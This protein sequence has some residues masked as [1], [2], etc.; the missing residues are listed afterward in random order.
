MFK[1]WFHW[2]YSG[3]VIPTLWVT[4][5]AMATFGI[6]FDTPDEIGIFSLLA[7]L[8]FGGT[9]LYACGV[10]ITSDWLRNVA[11]EIQSA[12]T[13]GRYTALAR[14]C[15]YIA[16]P[17]LTMTSVLI[18]CVLFTHRAEQQHRLSTFS[19]VLAP[20]DDQTIY[21]KPIE[22]AQGIVVFG[23]SAIQF[24]SM[25]AT[26]LRVGKE[27][28]I[29]M[30]RREGGGISISAKIYSEDGRIVTKVLKNAFDI[31]RN[32]IFKEERPD[33]STLIVIDQHDQRVLYIRYRNKYEIQFDARLWS[34]EL[35]LF[36]T[37][38][39]VQN[40]CINYMAKSSK[41]VFGFGTNDAI[42]RLD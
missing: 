27:D 41:A 5:L 13:E 16:T 9:W 14:F 25:P 2:K 38:L 1:P 36:V 6:M 24:A 30:N 18:A 21:C 26:I 40:I 15:L 32:N 28:M 8:F 3:V 39:P 17:F 31:N 42:F 20:A 4:A 37:G 11:R 12:A 33:D 34:P 19:G 22:G 23:A 29:T 35:G 7:Y 10:F